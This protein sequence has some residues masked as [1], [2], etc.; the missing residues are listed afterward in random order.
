MNEEY[1]I[2]DC[3]NDLYNWINV[4]VLRPHFL[5]ASVFI[6]F[7]LFKHFSLIKLDLKFET[8]VSIKSKT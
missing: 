2:S 4:F 8:N 1:S 5:P 6:I 7:N 3:A